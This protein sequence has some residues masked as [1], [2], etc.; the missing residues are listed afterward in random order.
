MEDSSGHKKEKSVNQNV[1]E[2]ITQHKYKNALLNNECL[3][4]SISRTK[5]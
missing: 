1:V 4:H 3:R 5:E 2:K